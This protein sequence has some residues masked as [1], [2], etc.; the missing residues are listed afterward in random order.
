MPGNRITKKRLDD[1]YADYQRKFTFGL[2]YGIIEVTSYC[3][4]RCPGCYMVSRHNLNQGEMTLEQSIYVLDLCRDYLGKEL[5][6]MDI[7]GGEPL[8]WPHLK[9]F[10]EALL[11][12]GIKPWIFTNMIAIT[13]ELA[14]W[15]YERQ[16]NVTGK[17]NINPDDRDLFPLQARLIRGKL[18]QAEQLIAGIKVFMNVG[19]RS[20]LF[21]LQNLIRKQNLQQVLGYYQ[22]CR[23]NNIGF[24]L[25][26]M[27]CGEK[28][29]EKYWKIAPTPQQLAEIVRNILNFNEENNFEKLEVVSPHIFGSCPFFDKGL[30][31]AVDGHIRAC[32]NSLKV[33]AHI[34][35]VDP[36]KKAYNSDLI[37]HR[38][39]L[40]RDSVGEPCHSCQKWE[41]CFGGC[42]A[43]VEGLG[44]PYGGYQLCPVPYL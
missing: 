8:L 22:W 7:L 35:D 32:S 21:R 30:Y 43:T 26:L 42:R 29:D 36:I 14:A 20:P 5:E 31:F 17:L 40:S 34:N 1:R 23:Q 27:G 11:Q 24:D 41:K 18:E 33:L 6:T 37:R 13:P 15:L 9:S 44:D 10:I 12:R 3:Q 4:L 25:E 2:H 38:Q 19:Y 28:I 16:I 39:W